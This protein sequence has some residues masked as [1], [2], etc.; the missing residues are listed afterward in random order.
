MLAIAKP[1]V[2]MCLLRVAP[3]DL[4]AS[5]LLLAIS[6]GA[7]AAVGALVLS[8]HSPLLSALAMGV[9]MSLLPGLFAFALLCARGLTAR[10]PQTWSAL[11]GTGAVLGVVALPLFALLGERAPDGPPGPAGVIFT[12]VWLALLVWNL[13]VSGHILRHALSVH[14][15]AGIGISMVFLWLSATIVHQL[16]GPS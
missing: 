6:V 15:T 4:P 14:I 3:Q 1:F 7:N 13:V 2:G 9:T 5:T 12:V 16:F 10:F 8:L 11:A